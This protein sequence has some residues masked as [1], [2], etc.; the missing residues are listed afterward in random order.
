MAE[1][2]DKPLKCWGLYPFVQELECRYY[3][4]SREVKDVVVKQEEVKV[5]LVE[6]SY[7]RCQMLPSSNH[8]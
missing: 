5:D 6:A 1:L 3:V 2:V 4:L 7:S 8:L